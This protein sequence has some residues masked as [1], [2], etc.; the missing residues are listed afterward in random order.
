M[1]TALDFSEWFCLV[2]GRKNFAID[3]LLDNG[4]LFGDPAEEAAIDRRLQRSQLLSVPVRLVWIGPY[5]MGKTHRLRHTAHI[6][7]SR[8]YNYTAHY[9]VCGDISEKTG[10]DRLH[11]QLVN[12]LDRGQLRDYVKAYL[13]RI[14]D[15]ESLPTLEEICG[16]SS[17]VP[18]A[19]K[20]FGAAGGD[21]LVE[22]TWKFLCGMKLSSN[23]ASLAGVTKPQLELAGDYVSVLAAI[24]T[25]V[26]NQTGKQLFYLIDEAEKLN[27]ITNKTAEAAW[28]ETLRAMLDIKNLNV[29]LTTGG[30]KLDQ[31]PTLLMFPDIVR[32]VQKDN[33]IQMEPYNPPL[34]EAFVKQLL[35]AWVDVGKRTTL[36]SEFAPSYPSY[37]SEVYPFE[38]KDAFERFIENVV[39]DPREA[40]PSVVLDKLNTI[41]VEAMLG[42]Q[43]LITDGLLTQLGYA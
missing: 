8:G 7:K 12:T 30:E 42:G 16:T 9:V 10:F 34:A 33:Y 41:A 4:L 24:A 5:G 19:F 21:D 3:P 22:P 43:R 1:S 14:E 15:G 20:R 25:V 23:D 11:Y 37:D 35:E 27:R 17:D 6:I 39:V 40:K 36:E 31:L 26:E 28:N 13:R 29:I 2:D 18:R 32:R 38:D